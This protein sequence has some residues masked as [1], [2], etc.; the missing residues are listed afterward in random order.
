MQGNIQE[1][2]GLFSIIY[3]SLL[4]IDLKNPLKSRVRERATVYYPVWW[5]SR[6][7]SSRT[8]DVFR[9]FV[10]HLAVYVSNGNIL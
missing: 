3:S 1:N 2:P 9:F 4:K 8:S 10:V 5:N 7:R 6:K